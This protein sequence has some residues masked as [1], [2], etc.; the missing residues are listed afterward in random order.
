MLDLLAERLRTHPNH[1][2]LRHGGTTCTFAAFAQRSN[3]AASWLKAQGVVPGDRVVLAMANR[4]NFL[5]LWFAVLELGATVVPVS[6]DL[7][8]ESLRYVLED[9]AARVLLTEPANAKAQADAAAMAGTELR[10]A[11]AEDGFECSGSEHLGKFDTGGP[12]K[13][14]A[15]AAILY[16]SGTT[17]RSKGVMISAAAYAA[18][19]REIVRAIGINEQ[20]RILTFLPLHHANPQ[21]YALMSALITGCSLIVLP[22]F[23][24]SGLLRDAALHQATGFT[25]V[26]TVLSILSKTIDAPQ[27]SSLRWC[28]GGGAPLG[29]W[30]DLE[31]KLGV[32]I[33]ELYGMTETGG[34]TTINS[35]TQALRGSVGKP[36]D[37]FEVVILNDDDEA[38]EVGGIGEIAVRPRRPGLITS[39]YCNKPQETLDCLSNLWFHTGDLG[40][41][42]DQGF[43]HFSG[44]KKDLFRRAGEMISPVA[45]E[46]VAA[47]HAQVAE[48]VAVAIPDDIL[49]EEIK[50][51][52]VERSPVDLNDLVNHLR[53]NLRSVELPRYLDFV[54]AIPKTST[55]KVQRFKLVENGPRVVDIQR[56]FAEDLTRSKHP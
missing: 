15:T 38:T 31:Q 41:Y 45:I 37:D 17:G 35:T 36:R 30:R 22:R 34:I 33:H 40:C 5:V 32:R 23:S 9:S 54:D 28:V 50:L 6:P 8:G 21:M 10:I 24:A 44:R 43:L 51:V 42:D 52:V 4:P 25:Y 3:A 26:G 12:H 18:A 56:E 48:C 55:E 13:R 2:F 7:T 19:G 20:D 11:P 29:V 39:G 49:G 27:T 47:R 16:T 53:K 14:F 46:T 1:A